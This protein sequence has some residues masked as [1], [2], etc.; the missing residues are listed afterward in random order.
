[1]APNGG[2]KFT[3]SNKMYICDF[4]KREREREHTHAY[5]HVLGWTG[6]RPERMREESLNLGTQH[7]ENFAGRLC[8]YSV[9]HFRRIGYI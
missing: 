7:R 5:M 9:N 1:M 4:L 2:L 3:F 8:D 6:G